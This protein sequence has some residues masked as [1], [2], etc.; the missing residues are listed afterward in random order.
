MEGPGKRPTIGR[1][2]RKSAGKTAGEPSS[3]RTDGGQHDLFPGR[4]S[5]SGLQYCE[6]VAAECL[7][8]SWRASGCHTAALTWAHMSQG[9]V[10]V[11]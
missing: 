4:R 10:K 2:P 11:G 7:R 8:V 3:V 1:A 6:P 9:F 5:Y